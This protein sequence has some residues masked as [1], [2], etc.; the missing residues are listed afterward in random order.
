MAAVASKS[1]WTVVPTPAIPMVNRPSAAPSTESTCTRLPRAAD[2]PRVMP[3]PTRL[4][5][6]RTP[7][8]SVVVAASSTKSRS[9]PPVEPVRVRAAVMPV[10][11]PPV[12]VMVEL[13]RTVS[14]PVPVSMLVGPLMVRTM[15]VSLPA[16]VASDVVR[17]APA[18]VLSMVKV[19]L[20][21][22]SPMSRS[23]KRV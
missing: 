5:S 16:Q 6:V 17:K 8:T 18:C 19:S 10:R 14:S 13:T 23:S 21:D 9:L 1:S 15:T 11:A 2:P 12:P 22:P 3:T 7:M 20:P 4:R